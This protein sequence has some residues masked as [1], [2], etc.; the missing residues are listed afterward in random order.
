MAKQ[1]RPAKSINTLLSQLNT[2]YP[3][4]SKVSDGIVGDTSHGA[5]K[6]DH[7]PDKNGV[8]KA[9]DITFD[10][11]PSD[12]I[13]VNGQWLA[14]TLVKNKDRRIKYIIWNRQIISSEKA[15]WIWRPYTGSNAHKHHVHISV[16]EDFDSID[17]WDLSGAEPRIDATF[18]PTSNIYTVKEG[19]TLSEIGQKFGVGV[20]ELKR[21]NSL[22]SDI[23]QVG[24]NLKVNG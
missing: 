24:Q 13:G 3:T 5:R 9:V 21:L 6:S 8:V 22:T 15:P 20:E 14:D 4:R 17:L 19:D 1:W 16:G 10:N 23:I 18:I 2:K 12:G 11:D 7:N